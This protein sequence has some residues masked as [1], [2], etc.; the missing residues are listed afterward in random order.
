MV[1]RGFH[2]CWLDPNAK[3]GDIDLKPATSLLEVNL[4]NN[5]GVFGCEFYCFANHVVQNLQH[6]L[7]FGPYSLFAL[8]NTSS[9][10]EI[11]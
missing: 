2:I 7:P 4:D 9:N 3:V 1:W 5:F 6:P 8:V 11:F 10:D